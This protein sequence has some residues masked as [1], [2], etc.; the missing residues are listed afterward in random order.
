MAAVTQTIPSFIQGVSQQSEVEMAPGFMNEIQNGVPDVTFGLQKRVGTKY[1]FNLPGI[2]TAEGASGFWF[3]IIRQEDEPYFGVIIPATVDGSGTITSYGNIKIWNFSGTACTVNFPAH[4]DGSAGNTYLSGSSRDDYK[5][6]SIEKSN[7][8]LNR[9]K[10]VTE[11]STT[12][13]A[14]TVERVSTYADLPTT[15]ISTTTVY[16]IINSK[17]TD[18]DDYYVQ[19]I[20]DAWTE[21][22]KPG[23]TDGFNNWT[24]PHVLRKISAT[25]FTFEEANYVDRAVGDNVTNPHPSFVNQTIEDCFSYFNRIG[26]LSNANVILSASLR[27]AY[28]NAGNQPVNFYGKSAQ[29]L[30]ASDP[31]DLNAVSVRSIL[32]TSVLPAPQGL[33]LFSN[34]E[35]FILFADQGVVT[36][37]TAIIKS[38][39]NYELDPIVP[40]VE[41]GDEFYYINKS[42]NF[43][44]TLMMIT[45][46]MENDPMVTEASRLAPEYVPSTV[47]NLYAN[48]QN[49]FI[50]LTDS[51]QEYMWFFKTHVEGQQRMMNA[52]FKW[53]LPGNVLSCVFNADNIFTIISTDNK[54]V[55]TS[56][57][58]NESADAEILLNKDTTN[59][60]FTGI[61]PHLDMWTKDLTSVSYNATTDITTITPTSNYP[62]IDSTEYEPIVVVS[63]VTGTSTSASRGMMFPLT[64]Q[65]NGTFTTPGD[66][67]GDQANFILGYR[68]EMIYDLPTT[69]MRA[70]AGSDYTASL[71][72][73]RYK[74]SFQDS[75][76][77]DFQITDIDNTFDYTDIS[78][79][80]YS[81]SYLTDDLPIFQKVLFT[82][83]I[84]R[85]NEFFRFRVF[86]NSPFPATLNKMSWEGQYAPRFYQRG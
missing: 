73:S 41:L 36:P 57:P 13:P 45:R 32:L 50:V 60:T 86:S 2:T 79:V 18:K 75:G 51:N 7:I 30:V 82:V 15:G 31:V 35:Q 8:I 12:I 66:R 81:E 43:T 20:N 42:A 37:Q 29:V 59:A 52:W 17:D 74:F 64:V 53:K 40:P 56:A 24:A 34:N 44:R 69:Y 39:G 10:V 38:I 85:R 9:S 28:I 48:P 25:E 14:A 19:Y 67:T 46:G 11:S 61:G 26:F 83:P 33:V 21:V 27:P 49:S 3:S 55:V 72:V 68:Y 23:I 58:L 47:N 6:L 54:L 78:S 84:Y 76:S 62:I 16:Q 80:T 70:S 65:S 5:V 1:L 4:S 77:V 63:A 22:A 71:I